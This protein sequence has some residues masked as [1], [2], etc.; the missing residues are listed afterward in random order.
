VA[1]GCNNAPTTLLNRGRK[2]LLKLFGSDIYFL[3]IMIFFK[4]ISSRGVICWA[5]GPGRRKRMSGL[6]GHETTWAVEDQ[7][8][9]KKIFVG[10]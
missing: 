6:L 5:G 1:V 10:P 4:K 2:L 9:S 3:K 7:G 8:H